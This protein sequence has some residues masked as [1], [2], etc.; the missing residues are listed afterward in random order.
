ML[1][2]PSTVPTGVGPHM[3]AVLQIKKGADTR[4]GAKKNTS[5]A[6]TIA[7]IWATSRHEL[8]TTEARRAIPAVSCFNKKAGLIN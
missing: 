4:D 3:A 6:A 7:A 5:S 1:L 2:S 8:L